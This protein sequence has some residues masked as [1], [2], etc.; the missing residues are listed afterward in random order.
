MPDRQTGLFTPP[1]Q[2]PH[3]Y[4]VQEFWDSLYWETCDADED[5]DGFLHIVSTLNGS[6]IK[7]KIADIVHT[8]AVDQNSLKQ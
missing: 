2:R 4:T 7:V 3:K 6:E 8:A 5:Y 1:L